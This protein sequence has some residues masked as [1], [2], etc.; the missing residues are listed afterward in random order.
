MDL[1]LTL[2]LTLELFRGFQYFLMLVP[3][4]WA[5]NTQEDPMDTIV[6]QN[7]HTAKIN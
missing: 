6:S 1:E 4:P 2:E 5:Q 3:S 7:I